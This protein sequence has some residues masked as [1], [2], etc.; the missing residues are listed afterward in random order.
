MASML[1]IEGFNCGNAETQIQIKKEKRNENDYGC[2]GCVGNDV[3][4][5]FNQRG[6]I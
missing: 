3:R 4:T 6:R 2:F 5:G 1:P